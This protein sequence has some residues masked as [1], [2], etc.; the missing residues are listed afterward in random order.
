MFQRSS[1]NV[2]EQLGQTLTSESTGDGFGTAVSMSADGKWVVVGA[3]FHDDVGLPGSG[4]VRMFRASS[5]LTLE[6]TTTKKPGFEANTKAA[7][8]LPVW[9]LS[10][11]IV[12]ALLIVAAV[13]F[14]VIRRPFSSKPDVT[15]SRVNQFSN[16]LYDDVNT[17]NVNGEQLDG[18]FVPGTSS[19]GYVDIPANG[20][21]QGST[22]YMDVAP[23]EDVDWEYN[24]D[25][26][27]MENLYDEVDMD[28]QEDV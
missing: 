11:L 3:P 26:A 21:I 28:D 10:L 22:G 16:P 19:T 27:N 9:G 6:Q 2:W 23:E 20:P 24:D 8:G 17:I 14:V 5:G 15:A 13:L 1:T 4:R 12:I 18:D 25:G 7:T